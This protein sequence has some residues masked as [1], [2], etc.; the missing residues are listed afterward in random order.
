MNRG[1]QMM[2]PQ[3]QQILSQINDNF[4]E[5]LINNNNGKNNSEL[6]KIK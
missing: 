6:D 3:D 5:N 4:F 1:R 2:T